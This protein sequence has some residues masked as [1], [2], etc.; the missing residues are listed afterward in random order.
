MDDVRKITNIDRIIDSLESFSN[1]NDLYIVFIDLCD[2][3]DFKQFC[4]ESDIPDNFWVTRQLI[5]LSRTAKIIKSHKGTVIKTI[6]DEVM[7]TFDYNENPENIIKT[8]VEVFQSFDNLKMYN[9]GKFKIKCK[10]SIDCGTC[11]NGQITDSIIFDP[12]GP[13]V[14]RCARISKNLNKNEIVCSSD[15]YD[16]IKQNSIDIDIYRPE[17]QNEELKG[18]GYTEFYKLYIS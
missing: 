13:C 10:A 16:I 12:V 11:H 1:T 4:L 3:T 15:F 5:F 2:S 9:K 8:C 6:G 14:D 17:K 18:L 7:A